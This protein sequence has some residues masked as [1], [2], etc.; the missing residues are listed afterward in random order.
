[1]ALTDTI[2]RFPLLLFHLVKSSSV[3]YNSLQYSCENAW[4][5]DNL[6]SYVIQHKG[7]KTVVFNKHK[8]TLM[9]HLS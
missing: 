3:K 5:R 8:L 9:S 7:F 1:M 2:T 6:W 4:K